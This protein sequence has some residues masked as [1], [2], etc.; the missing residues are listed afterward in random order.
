VI[1]IAAEDPLA[2]QSRALID[3]SEVFIRTVFRPEACYTYSPEELAN[4]Q[5]TFFVAREADQPLG[6]V[7]LVDMQDYA[8]IKRLFV[9]DQ[10]RGKGVA[11]ALM[12]AL[13]A[14]AAA[15]GHHVLK[16]E[17]GEELAAAVILYRRM[18]YTE[19]APFGAYGSGEQSLFMEK[20]LD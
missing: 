8:E 18:G 11:R 14:H 7:A 13:E 6:C 5:S 10:C 1:F 3:E 2:P 9:P 12:E 17:T 16:L 4:P 15:N 19:C 20:R